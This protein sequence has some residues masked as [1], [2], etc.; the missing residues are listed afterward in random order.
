MYRK[1]L[2]AI[3]VVGM[4][5]CFARPT[6]AA[7]SA[8]PTVGTMTFTKG[9]YC[10]GVVWFGSCM[11]SQETLDNGI[12]PKFQPFSKYTGGV[13]GRR[14]QLGTTQVYVVAPTDTY[15]QG[16]VRLYD[17]K[18]KLLQT[19]KPF[20]VFVTTGFTGGVL[21]E[22]FNKTAYLA[23]ATKKVGY[24][25]KVYKVGETRLTAVANVAASSATV[26]GTIIVKFLKLYTNQ[27]AL[28]TMLSGKPKTLKIWKYSTTKKTFLQDTSAATRAKVILKG[29]S[30]TA[31]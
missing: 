30:I 9:V 20:G 28:V 25:V 1:I 23:V 10:A 8:L 19:V 11:D 3:A 21:S 22:S 15:S 17:A 4:M 29:D 27:S 16:A 26:K 7:E 18:Y 5:F 13:L 14:V 12:A 31:K 6:V 2:L 24:S